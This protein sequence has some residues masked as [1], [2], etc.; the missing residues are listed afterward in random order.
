MSIQPILGTGVAVATAAVLAVAGPLPAAHAGA[1]AGVAAPPASTT[2][3]VEQ[4]TLLA[5]V[6]AEP[7][8]ADGVLDITFQDIVNAFNGGYGPFIDSTDLYYPTDEPREVTGFTGVAYYLGDEV[9]WALSQSGLP[10]VAPLADFVFQNVTSYFYEVSAI[11]A[12]HVALAEATGG[13]YT[14]FGEFLQRVFNPDAI[15]AA[16][17]DPGAEARTL[18]NRATVD[19]P[20]VPLK[21]RAA[22][23]NVSLPEAT[24]T[25]G[26]LAES[27]AEQAPEPVAKPK[28]VKPKL[29]VKKQSPLSEVADKVDGFKKNLTDAADNVSTGLKKL[30]GSSQKHAGAATSASKG[31]EDDD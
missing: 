5:A 13:R 21:K 9:L 31:A 28:L 19:G 11:A 27:V 24:P 17:P 26:V 22:V 2:L 7:D 18:L 20:E 10:V 4:L 16:E 30:A 15:E 23:V 25:V 29:N 8:A 12:F 14:P 3:T 1:T 6:T